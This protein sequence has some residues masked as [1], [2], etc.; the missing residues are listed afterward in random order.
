VHA[1]HAAAHA[2]TLAAT[3]HGVPVLCWP[4]DELVRRLLA[5]GRMPRLLLVPARCPPPRLTDDL[6][7][8]IRDP[9]DALDVAARATALAR[10]AWQP[11]TG[12]ADASFEA[13]DLDA[14]RARS[15]DSVH[16]GGRPCVPHLDQD[17][18]LLRVGS[19]WVSLS[20][21]QLSV[22]APLVARLGSIVSREEFAQL[23]QASAGSG[24]PAAIKSM[25]ARLARR[26]ATVGLTLHVVHG[27]GFLLDHA[28]PDR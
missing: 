12:E 28:V 20:D 10:R 2:A 26:V 23:Y 11:A 4:R 13:F 17:G 3:P 15:A 21:R 24:A 25:M 1:H 18:G 9:V 14:W 5:A 7:D 19:R 27:K 16:P 8:W 22:V 6:E